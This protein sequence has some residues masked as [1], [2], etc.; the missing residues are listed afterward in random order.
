MP[1][2]FS[3]QIFTFDALWQ[4]LSRCHFMNLYSILRFHGVRG[5]KFYIYLTNN[6]LYIIV[7]HDL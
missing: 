5:D 6:T 2:Q 7:C 1:T 3:D 4:P